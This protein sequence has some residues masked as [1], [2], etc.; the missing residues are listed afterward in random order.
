M[1][2]GEIIGGATRQLRLSGQVAVGP[3]SS[4]EHGTRVVAQGDMRAQM[5]KFLAN[6]DDVLRE[7]GMGRESIVHLHFFTTDPDQ[8]M[9]NYDAYAE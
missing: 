5:E 6:V 4:T 1:S 8:F 7:G 9:A 3:S 2:Q